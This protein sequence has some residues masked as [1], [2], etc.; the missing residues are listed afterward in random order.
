MENQYMISES[1]LKYLLETEAR[2]IVLEQDGV[3]NWTWYMEGAKDFLK[4][5][6]CETFEELVENK[7]THYS[8][9]VQN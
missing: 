5:E 3:D 9:I 4:E 7:L 1:Q 6:N 8:R 2:M